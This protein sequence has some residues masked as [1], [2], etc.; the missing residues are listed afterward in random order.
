MAVQKP[1]TKRTPETEDIG[2]FI[3]ARRMAYTL[4]SSG[5][6][7]RRRRHVPYLTQTEV[8]ERVGV[9]TVVISQIEQGRYPNLN[10]SILRRIATTLGFSRQQEMYVLGLLE[11]RPSRQRELVH[12]PTWITESV[13]DT[14]HPVFVISPAYDLLAWNNSATTMLGA[15]ATDF[16]AAANPVKSVF[17]DPAMKTFFID[18]D[19]YARSIVSGLRM[20]Y[21]VHPDFREYIEATAR[22]L[23][24]K[25][26]YFHELWYLDDPLTVPTIEKDLHHSQLGPIRMIQVVTVV[27]EAPHLTM[28]EFLP[29][30]EETRTKLATL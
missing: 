10:F 4:A 5:E 15:Y 13:A 26:T 25:D 11:N 14:R 9:S 29:A 19:E 17:H 27:V 21:G 6:A 18:W 2:R 24:G 23:A 1:M 12:V 16:Y 22:E 8:A 28:V 3:R 30:D 7:I 20:S